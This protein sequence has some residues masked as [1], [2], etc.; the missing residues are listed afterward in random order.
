MRASEARRC[1]QEISPQSSIAAPHT[2][3]VSRTH[4]RSGVADTSVAGM[5]QTE[6][7]LEELGLKLPPMPSALASYI[8]CV[9]SGNML[10]TAGHVAFRNFETKELYQG[11]V[12]KD[13]T[14]EEAADLAKLIGLELMATM[15][16]EIGDLDKVKRIVKVVGFVNCPDD[17]GQ[18]PEVINGCSN[19]M[20]AVFGVERGTHARSA[21]GT[22]SLPRQAPVEIELIA[23]VAD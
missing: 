12:G 1:G 19:V 13:Y 9:R 7:K 18:Q 2:R 3:I 10:H 20:T 4:S 15:K 16:N 14:V 22:N 8:P 21:V 11:K 17:F 6:A 5:V 23:E